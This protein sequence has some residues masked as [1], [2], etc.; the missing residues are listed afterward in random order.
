M[1]GETKSTILFHQKQQ[2]ITGIRVYENH[3]TPESVR[4]AN[5]DSL[6][7]PLPPDAS[8]SKLEHATGWFGSMVAS[9]RQCD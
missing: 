1:T 7:E 5:I 8:R 4:P 6:I 9:G 3:I 2:K